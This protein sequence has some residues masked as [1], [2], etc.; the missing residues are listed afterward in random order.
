MLLCLW[1]GGILLWFGSLHPDDIQPQTGTGCY[2]GSGRLAQDETVKPLAELE[3]FKHL[4]NK[5]SIAESITG[6]RIEKKTAIALIVWKKKC[7]NATQ[8]LECFTKSWFVSHIHPSGGEAIEN[9]WKTKK[10]PE[11]W[12]EEPLCHFQNRPVRFVH[13]LLNELRTLLCFRSVQTATLDM[14]RHPVCRSI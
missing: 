14:H 6:F 9:I 2:R 13:C 4:I 8:E 7:S 5:T 10:N 1:D 11:R 3:H 12:T